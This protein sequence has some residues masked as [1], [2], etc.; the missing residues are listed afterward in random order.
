VSWRP[1]FGRAFLELLILVVD[2][3][4]VVKND[5]R[6]RDR[7]SKRGQLDSFFTLPQVTFLSGRGANFIITIHVR[8]RPS[9]TYQERGRRRDFLSRTRKL[10]AAA[11][12]AAAGVS[13]SKN[14]KEEPSS[15]HHHACAGRRR[16]R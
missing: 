3:E 6:E 13:F 2:P 7:A 9:G 5:E 10:K 11:A 14:L 12:A 15:Q 4:S 8:V 1:I 16:R